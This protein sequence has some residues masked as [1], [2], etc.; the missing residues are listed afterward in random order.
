MDNI[1][2]NE[3]KNEPTMQETINWLNTVKHGPKPPEEEIK[4]H[5]ANLKKYI[6]E[7]NNIPL[8]EVDDFIVRQK[9]RRT[10]LRTKPKRNKPCPC[11]SGKK[12]KKCCGRLSR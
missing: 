11:G 8:D 5:D 7:R 12:Y 2:I 1:K 9:R 6:A 4:R 3:A 10:A